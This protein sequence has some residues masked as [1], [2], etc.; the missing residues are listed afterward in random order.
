MRTHGESA[1][2]IAAAL[3][4]ALPPWLDLLTTLPANVTHSFCSQLAEST[5]PSCPLL[6]TWAVSSRGH[7]GQYLYSTEHLWGLIHP[8]VRA[9]ALTAELQP[10]S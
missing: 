7:A 9:R 1:G 10:S 8:G 2:G 3:P 6:C 5:P 4:G